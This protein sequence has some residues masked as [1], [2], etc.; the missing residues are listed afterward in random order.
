MRL[1]L[2]ISVAAL[3]VALGVGAYVTDLPAY[4]GSDP[5]T[6]NRCHVMSAEYEGWLHGGH[7][8]WATCVDCHAPHDMIPKY[9]YKAYA[10][11]RDAL[12]FT[13]NLIPQSI[14]A[15]ALTQAIVQENCKR[16][17]AEAVSGIGDGGSD[18]GR[19]CV[20]CHR[21]VAHGPRGGVLAA[22]TSA[23]R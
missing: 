17:H 18:A 7:G 20:T 22:F 12:F 8:R 21:A 14:R 11:T 4:L 10:G 2:A 9:L 23:G 3:A 19:A 13:L 5:A 1:A 15:D 16:C 6:C